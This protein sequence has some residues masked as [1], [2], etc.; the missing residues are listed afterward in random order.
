MQNARLR[1]TVDLGAYPDLMVLMLGFHAR[2]LRAV[3]AL[4]GVGRGLAAL[5]R[6]PPEGLLCHE[7]MLLGW[8]H[9]GMRQY[10]RDPDSLARF[11]RAAPHAGWWRDFLRDPKGSGFWH[12]A[13]SAR[14]GIEAIYVEM[15]ERI[16]LGRFAPVCAAEGPLLTSQGR[17]AAHAETRRR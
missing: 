11:T 10:W 1:E 5:R 15:P 9:V 14:G 12:E 17:L 8:N 2:R 7:Q 16:G 6:E 13:Y 4:I 3:P